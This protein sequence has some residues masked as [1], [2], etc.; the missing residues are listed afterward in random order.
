MTADYSVRDIHELL[1]REGCGMP[2]SKISVVLTR[3]KNRG[4]IEEIK[5]GS[6]PHGALFRVPQRATSQEP[7]P[8]TSTEQIEPATNSAA[9]E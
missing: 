6:G 5:R 2:A 4:K 7:E 1:E 8:V 3:F 9:T